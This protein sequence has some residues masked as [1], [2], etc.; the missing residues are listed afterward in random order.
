MRTTRIALLTGAAAILLAGYAGMAEA[1]PPQ[2]HV[3]T[4][5]L[6]DGQIE[7]VRYAGDLPPIIVLAP[8]TAAASF[9]PMS[10]LS[11][12]D[13]I[14]A[15]MDRQAEV[16]LQNINALM[17]STASG[18]GA[19]PAMSGPGVCMRSIQITYT[20][21]GLAPHVVS[22]TSSECGSHQDDATPAVRREMPVPNHAPN[23]IEARAT[24]PY[25]G[26][27]HTVGDWQR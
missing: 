7:Q 23:V 15:A 21:N 2:T 11:A 10:P 19:M 4:L 5:R 3:L 13:Q 18:F 16:M 6:P 12:L 17:A 8:D 26:L 9:G 1:Q 14:S 20:G 25:S 27:V 24:S 22:Q